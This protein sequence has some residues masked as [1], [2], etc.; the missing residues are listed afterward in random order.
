[1]ALISFLS[2]FTASGFTTGYWPFPGK[3]TF[4]SLVAIVF[5][6]FLQNYFDSLFFLLGFISFIII[7]GFWSCNKIYSIKD[8]DPK[9]C[10]IDEWSGQLITIFLLPMDLYWLISGFL[11]FRIL[12]IFKP[13]GIKKLEKIGT[14]AGIM[15]DDIFAGVIG[16]FILLLVSI[17]I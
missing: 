11:I 12:D 2:K 6:Y 10:V 13:F 15:L 5:F 7:L 9:Y 16:A 14:G 17:F 3:G 8:P 1:M 4:A